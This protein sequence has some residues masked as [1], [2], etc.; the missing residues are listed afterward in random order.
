MLV[1]AAALV[2]AGLAPAAAALQAVAT[3]LSDEPAL[4][5]ALQALVE[6]VFGRAD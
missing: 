4:Q 1:H 3:P 6:A 5:H 2:R